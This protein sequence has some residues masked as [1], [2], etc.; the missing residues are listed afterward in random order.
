VVVLITAAV[1]I[2][3][4]IGMF[5]EMVFYVPRLE[6]TFRDYNMRLPAISEHVLWYCRVVGQYPYLWAVLPVLDVAVLVYLYR[7]GSD[8]L[9]ILWTGFIIL[10]CVAVFLDMHLGLGMAVLKLYEGLHR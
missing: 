9:L 5:V 10:L 4:W 8:L 1:H 2:L 3:L 7:R 6:A